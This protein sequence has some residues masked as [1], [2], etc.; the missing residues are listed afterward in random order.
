M[1]TEAQMVAYPEPDL[2]VRVA[3][4]ADAVRDR[5]HNLDLEEVGRRRVRLVQGLTLVRQAR[6]R[7]VVHRRRRSVST[8]A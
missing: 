3:V 2:V 6:H 1:V 5:V 4:L 7:S 8:R